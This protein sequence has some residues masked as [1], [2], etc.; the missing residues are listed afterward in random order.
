MS[1]PSK[2]MLLL[3]QALKDEVD[4]HIASHHCLVTF[5]KKYDVSKTALFKAFNSITGMS[6]LPYI[7][8]ARA[9]AALAIMHRSPELKLREIA[10]MVGCKT[11]RLRYA[12]LVTFNQQPRAVLREIRK[13]E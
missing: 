1:A 6:L 3:A 4:R 7:E 13:Q 12:F 11:R 5:A 8:K 9:E 10:Q 2:R